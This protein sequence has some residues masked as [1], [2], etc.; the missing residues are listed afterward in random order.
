M[1]IV[2]LKYGFSFRQIMLN[3]EVRKYFISDVLNIPV[4]EIRS[5]RLA[6]SFLWKQYAWRKP[7]ILDMK[8]NLKNE[9][10]INMELQ[11]RML[12]HRDERSLFYPAKMF[13]EDLLF[14]KKFHRRKK[15]VCISVL[16]FNLDENPEYHKSYR[17]RD[18]KGQELSDMFEIHVIELRKRVRGED[19]MDGWIQLFRAE[20]EEELD[21]IKTDSPGIMEAIRKVK[22]MSL[23]KDVQ[24]LHQAHVKQICHGYAG[25]D[26]VMRQGKAEGRAE[27]ILLLLA[28]KGDIS[29]EL[30]G[31]IYNQKDLD[32]LNDW[33]IMAAGA[34]S[35][36]EFATQAGI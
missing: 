32:V 6:N 35:V 31:I 30:E 28:V 1:E 5:V 16:N 10:G 18:E 20:T 7:G 14:G 29:E 36:R 13:T 22:A 26:F 3:Q 12:D 19:P 11:I 24:A 25:D 27:D 15:C 4:E 2:S 9:N 8:V 21:M 23:R 17:L 33:L 34:G